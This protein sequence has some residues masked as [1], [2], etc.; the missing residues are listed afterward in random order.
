MEEVKIIRSAIGGKAG[1][2]K[3]SEV[4]S[5]ENTSDGAPTVFLHVLL[6]SQPRSE[7]LQALNNGAMLPSMYS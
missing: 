3:S 7:H 6:S 2:L 5:V 1:K 4:Y